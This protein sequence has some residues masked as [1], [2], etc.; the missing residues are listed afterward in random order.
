M[1]PSFCAT[2]ASVHASERRQRPRS[3]I[4]KS[5]SQG[6]SLQILSIASVLAC[7]S[8]LAVRGGLSGVLSTASTGCSDRAKEREGGGVAVRS[9]AQGGPQCIDD[10]W[11]QS[12]AGFLR[13]SCD[14]RRFQM[15]PMNRTK[16]KMTRRQ[17]H[18]SAVACG[19][20][21]ASRLS[22]HHFEKTKSIQIA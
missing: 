10:T 6:C 18:G 13:F 14:S 5:R 17:A 4:L 8:K 9:R 3:Q 1:R 22:W 11:F 7:C 2:D 16:G 19:A 20:I 12:W 21:V 15:S